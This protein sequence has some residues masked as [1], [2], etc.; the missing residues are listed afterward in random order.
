MVTEVGCCGSL[1]LNSEG[2]GN[3]IGE[4]TYFGNNGN[5]NNCKD[6]TANQILN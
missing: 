3:G 4:W 2:S 6:R 1:K 5:C